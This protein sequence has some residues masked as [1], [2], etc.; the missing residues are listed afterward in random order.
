MGLRRLWMHV[1]PAMWKFAGSYGSFKMLVQTVFSVLY[2]FLYRIYYKQVSAVHEDKL[3]VA[4]LDYA[5]ENGRI[6]VLKF[7]VY[8]CDIDIDRVSRHGS[9]LHFAVKVFF[10]CD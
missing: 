1:V 5:A 4:A 6:E 9:A 10:V 7:L 2:L 3:G 8:E